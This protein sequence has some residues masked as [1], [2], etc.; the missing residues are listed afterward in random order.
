MS[1]QKSSVCAV[2][3]FL[4]LG[5]VS[6]VSAQSAPAAPAAW[7]ASTA[8]PR[9][10]KFSGVVTDAAGNPR[11]GVTGM[12]FAL[13]K[14]QAG[15]AALWLETQNVTLDVQGRYT[16]LLGANS[17]EG[18]PLDAFTANEAQWLGIHP[19]GLPEQ[20]VLL[21]SVPYA[22]KAADAETLGG[23]PASSFVLA[24]PLAAGATTS[25]GQTGTTPTAAG[26]SVPS[27]AISGSGTVNTL[28]KFDAS[29]TNLISSS[30]TDTGTAVSTTEPVGIGTASPGALL[31]VEFTTSA[32]T[33]ALLSNINYNNS[34]AV[35]NAVV[36]AFDMNFMDGSTAAN[37]SKQTARIA[38]I[39]E[40]GATG[41]VTAFDTALTTTEVV[42]ANA[43]F[44]VRSINIE[45]PN[46]N[47]GTT[48]SNFTGLYIGSPSGAGTV[49]S[50][51]ALVTE[52]NAGNVGIGTTSP[53]VP[54]EVAGNLTV[55]TPGVI[56]G[57]GSGLTSLPAPQ[58]ASL[59]GTIPPAALN[60]VNGS[61]LTNLNAA[62]LTGTVPSSIL[63]G[64]NGFGLT[65]VDAATLAGFL[66]SA[67]ATTLSNTFTGNQSVTGNLSL[68]G[69]LTG[70]AASLNSLALPNTSSDGTMG[71]IALGD[72]LFL[73]SFGTDN[74]FVGA[75]AGNLTMTGTANAAVGRNAL[76]ANTTGSSNSA[77]GAGALKAN[78][79]N[80]CNSAFGAGALTANTTGT[81]NSAFGNAVL[82]ANTTGSGNTAFGDVA[83]AANTTGIQNSAFG[84]AA[85]RANTTGNWNAAFGVNALLANTTANYNSAFGIHALSSLSGGQS[86]I[87][88]GYGA[89][90]NLTGAESN[91]IYIGNQGVAGE[92]NTIRIGTDAQQT[93]T[94]I[95]GINGATSASGVEVFVNSSDQLGTVTSS[96]RFKHQIA[97][98]GAESDL[99]MKLR[100]VAFYYKPEF[101]EAQTRQYG[102]VAEEVA[103]VAPQLV[104]Y[105]KDGAPQTVRYH[106]VNAMLLNA[107]QKQQR[108]LEEQRTTIGKQ[109]SRIQD[110]EAR[111]A[112]LEAALA[113]RH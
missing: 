26:A 89:G 88:L 10:V 99:L 35:T 64:V 32:P 46:M 30:I 107:V 95:A 96:R 102:L 51:F 16:V 79:T 11:S 12:T 18:V 83:L 48:L 25:T 103:Q 53:T 62:N 1:A 37:L 72:T 108:L 94:F 92:S 21:V 84:N 76:S 104:V 24:A 41:G 77:F 57:N 61:G 44:P 20:R 28:A 82:L 97:D 109:E 5:W 63:S 78:T 39:R 70:G 101:D 52:P 23:I 55:D 4:V 67:F 74:T 60:G 54:L 90:D 111:L 50:K 27:P 34:T 49:T 71:V 33:N 65:N 58:A 43:P 31:D 73:H 7:T 66:P 15:G 113:E 9:L 85:L 80:C 100:P 87:A 6:V 40:A 81:N 19:E 2:M 45:G 86:N 59:V 36:S 68:S 14:D 42:N 105:D 17:A 22:L 47:T 38:Y 13:Y 91:N 8:V 69:S 56:T 112:K 106:F 110:L 75:S 29:T 93:A 3:L 98:I